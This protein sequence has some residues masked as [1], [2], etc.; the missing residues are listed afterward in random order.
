MDLAR[1]YDGEIINA[2]SMQIYG[3]LPILTAQPSS[4]ERGDIAHHLYGHVDPGTPYSVGAWLTQVQSTIA[5]VHSKGKAAILVGGTGLYFEALTKG[6]AQMPPIAETAINDAQKIFDEEGVEALRAEV[7]RIDPAAAARILGADRQRLLRAYSVFLQTGRSLTS[8]QAD[9]KPVLAAGDWRGVCLLPD[10]EWLYQRIAKRFSLMM[11]AG[12]LSEVAAI[13][14]KK[15]S[16]SLTAMK[17]LGLLPL[18]RLIKGEIDR[19]DAVE[20]AVRDTRRYAKRQYTWARGRFTAW[21][22][23]T[24]NDPCQHKE[25]VIK[26]GF[27]G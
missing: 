3:G 9:T 26:S 7:A 12:A 10:R 24:D 8:F 14:E 6:L 23:I 4:L 18:T 25:Q 19:D 17:A 5:G 16:G 2:D 20:E 21:P 27:L 1:H 11:D 15:L 13:M 22:I